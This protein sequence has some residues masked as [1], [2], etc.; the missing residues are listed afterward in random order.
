MLEWLKTVGDVLAFFAA[1]PAIATL[2][3]TAIPRF[4]E[5]LKRKPW[6]AAAATG[7]IA[8]TI[9]SFA[10]WIVL[11]YAVAGPPGPRGPEGPKG[12]PGE[13]GPQGLRG[14]KGDP[15][16]LPTSERVEEIVWKTLDKNLAVFSTDRFAASKRPAPDN[17]WEVVGWCPEKSIL[18]NY[19]CQVGDENPA[20]AGGG[21]FQNIGITQDHRFHC[22]WTSVGGSFRASGWGVCLRMTK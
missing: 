19:Y 18:V 9:V 17:N 16:D 21:V 7:L 5:W 6:R 3:G 4:R 8:A 12:G 2:I 13:Q 20:S 15:G 22:L 10:L 1:L 11:P 14:A